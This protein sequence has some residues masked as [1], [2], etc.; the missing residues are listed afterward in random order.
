MEGANPLAP[1]SFQQ[2][3]KTTG[4]P[5]G[6]VN[7]LNLYPL[8][9]FEFL[10]ALGEETLL[11]LLR[12]KKD[13]EPLAALLHEKLS[14]LLRVFLFTGGMPEAVQCYCRTRDHGAVRAIQKDILNAYH[15][16]AFVENFTATELARRYDAELHYWISEGLK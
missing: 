13:F 11:A 15:R 16:G 10:E 7:F 3:R 5:V 1:W 8:S 2:N 4:F 9:F 6:K 14:G 12:E